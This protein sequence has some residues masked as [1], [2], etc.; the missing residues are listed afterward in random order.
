MRLH[1]NGRCQHGSSAVF[2]MRNCHGRNDPKGVLWQI[3][4]LREVGVRLDEFEKMLVEA[5]EMDALFVLGVVSAE[6]FIEKLDEC[7]AV[8]RR[9]DW[10]LAIAD[11]VTWC[12]FRLTTMRQL[13]RA[14]AFAETRFVG[15]Q[16]EPEV[17]AYH[18]TTFALIAAGRGDNA[19][20]IELYKS[21]LLHLVQ[22]DSPCEYEFIARQLAR[23]Y[24]PN[25]PQA[26]RQ[27]LHK[28][29]IPEGDAEKVLASFG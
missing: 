9:L 5:Y 15:L 3:C 11:L 19:R 21:A 10:Q 12:V 16:Q 17:R 1:A 7:L 28:A 18:N 2:E 13:E 6:E 22:T 20:A 27:V 14:T 25:D 29:D 26:A 8:C 4:R 23:S 24:W